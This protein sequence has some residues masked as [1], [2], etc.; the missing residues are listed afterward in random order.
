VSIPDKVF[1][2]KHAGKFQ[3]RS[4]RSNMCVHSRQGLYDQTCVSI[5]G[6]VFTIKHACPFQARS[7]RS[8]M[9]VHSRQVLDG[10]TCVFIPGKVFTGKHVCSFQARTWRQNM[11]VHS[12]QGFDSKTCVF[13]PG[14]VFTGKHVCSFQARIWQQNMCVHSTSRQG[15]DGKTCVF[16][17]GKDL[18]AKHMCLTVFQTRALRPSI[19]FCSRQVPLKNN[20]MPTEQIHLYNVGMYFQAYM[21]GLLSSSRAHKCLFILGKV[22]RSAPV[23]HSITGF[24]LHLSSDLFYTR[25]CTNVN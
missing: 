18:T 4:L 20:W 14:K 22:F 7:L 5:P 6:K 23:Y 25:R 24:Y 15:L 16:F 19:C 10:Q 3:A 1:T 11:C 12:R 8:S 17:P 9:C 21:R 2:A 13:I